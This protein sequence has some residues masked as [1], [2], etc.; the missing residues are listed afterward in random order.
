MGGGDPAPP[1]DGGA[2]VRVLLVLYCPEGH[3]LEVN[4]SR[5]DASQH[6]PILAFCGS[7]DEDYALEL[8]LRRATLEDRWA[9][10]R[11]LQLFHHQ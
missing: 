11:Q 6:H 7:C 3:S 8:H 5:E 10:D 1:G 2:A 4:L 9:R